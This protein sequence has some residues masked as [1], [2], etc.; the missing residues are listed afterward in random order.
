MGGGGRPRAR[1][2]AVAADE[3]LLRDAGYDYADAFEV[4]VRDGDPRTAEQFARLALEAAP[5]AV[6]W[7]IWLAH[8]YLLRFRLAPRSSPDHVL[9]WT[10]VTS[11]PDIV[12]LA[13]VSPLL[14]GDIVG[15][16]DAP[17]RAVVTTYVSF[18][19]RRAARVL[20][21][22][23]GPVHRRIAPYLMERA[24]AAAG[25]AVAATPAR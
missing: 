1:R 20:M 5:A 6:R 13:A 16:R 11:E 2:V 25:A 23:A 8:R 9:G 10:V 3:P 12:H 21:G 4:R 17:T 14:R 18:T 19:R 15:R 7:T 22:V 24:A